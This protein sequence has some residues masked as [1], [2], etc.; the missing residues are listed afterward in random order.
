MSNTETIIEILRAVADG[1]RD[2]LSTTLKFEDYDSMQL[3]RKS[4][5]E[6][7]SAL[8]S[9]DEAVKLLETIAYI[10]QDSWINHNGGIDSLPELS[11]KS[12]TMYGSTFGNRCYWQNVVITRWLKSD[13]DSDSNSGVADRRWDLDFDVIEETTETKETKTTKTTKKKRQGKTVPITDL[14][15]SV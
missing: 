9:M 5:G 4:W 1:M 10:D 2:L 14:M 3:S 13:G 15:E 8:R 11:R 12:M 7:T 6:A